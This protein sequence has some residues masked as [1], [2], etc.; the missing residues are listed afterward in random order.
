M[1]KKSLLIATGVCAM[2][3]SCKPEKENNTIAPYTVPKTYSFASANY[4][5]STQRVNMVVALGAYLG[6]ANVGSSTVALSQSVV[7]NMFNNT[8]NPFADATLNTSG[9]NVRSVTDAA[10]LYKSYADSMLLFNTGVMA[11]PGRGGY[12]PRGTNKVIVGPRGLE[13][14]QAYMKGS[15][16]SLFFKEGVRLLTSVRT[17]TAT[18]TTAAQR[19]WDEAFGYV[20]IPANYDTSVD[21][22]STDPN[23][24][25]LWGG[26]F[27]ERG[28]SIQA[29]GIMFN[30]FLKGRA[31]I[32]AKDVSVR[33]AQVDIILAKWEQLAGASALD[34][35]TEPTTTAL[36]GNLGSQ[37]HEL[38]EGFGFIA[39][40][41]Y[42]PASTKLTAANYEILKNIIHKDF[43]TLVNQP[44]FTDLVTAQNILKSA[45]GL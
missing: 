7:D 21:Y 29:G 38:S 39:A 40:L 6:T 34:Y 5:T 36:V 24:P 35:M 30:A 14:Q 20:G 37:F 41:Q 22:A 26:Y 15:M 19:A 32:G 10:D 3:A 8:G 13:Y 31:A 2:M 16:G 33:N 1:Y 17:M 43:Y 18:D 11:A 28:K 9:I 23:R 25:L 4:T 27:K 44:G 42:R 12:L 45:Y